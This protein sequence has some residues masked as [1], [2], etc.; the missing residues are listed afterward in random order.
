MLRL[1]VGA[2][3]KLSHSRGGNMVTINLVK[4][5]VMREPRVVL[6]DETWARFALIIFIVVSGILI[7]LKIGY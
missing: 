5:W 2:A 1:A 4:P 3:G 6:P 7:F